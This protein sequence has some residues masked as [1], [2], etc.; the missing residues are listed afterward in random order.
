[1]ETNSK[2]VATALLIM[3][4]QPGTMQMLGGAAAA[5]PL[6]NALRQ[7]IQAARASSIPVIYVVV[8]FREGFP[9]VSSYNKGFSAIRQGGGFPGLVDPQPDPAVAP[10]PGDMIVTKRR[11]S[12]FAGSDLEVILRAHRIDHLVLTGIATSGVVL[13]T[14]REAADRDYKLTV[15]SDACADRDLEVH[16]VLLGKV[17]PRQADVVTAAEWAAG[18]AGSTVDASS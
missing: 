9:E 17:F 18:L 6:V 3:D 4:I 14:I 15:L 1:M 7:A 2:T 11:V 8:G 10:Q 16:G 12:A 5:A 13:S